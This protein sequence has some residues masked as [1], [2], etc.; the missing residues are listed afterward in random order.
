MLY[1]STSKNTHRG[2]LTYGILF[3]IG[4]PFLLLAIGAALWVGR[5]SSARN[6]LNQ[7]IDRLRGEGLPVDNASTQAY[8]EARTSAEDT[9][10]WLAVLAELTSDPFSQSAAGVPI[11]DGEVEAGV[12]GPGESWAEEQTTR[13]FLNRWQSLHA[14]TMRLATDAGPVRF[15]IDFDSVNTLLPNAQNVRQAARLLSLRGQVAI[16]DR[17]SRMVRRSVESLLGCSNVCSG[18]PFLVSQLITFAIDGM[19]LEVLQQAIRHD[20]LDDDDLKALLPKLL[21]ST[22]I[23]NQWKH[24]M[25]GERAMMLPV[26]DDPS[27]A[28]D[29]GVSTLPGRSRDALVYLNYMSRVSAIPTEDIDEFRSEIA[30]QESELSNLLQGGMLQRYDTI[31]TGLLTPSLAAA[32]DV[33][34]KQATLHRLA[35]LAIA[36]RLYEHEHGGWPQSLEDLAE[37]PLIN[38][39]RLVPPGGKPFGYRVDDSGATIWGFNLRE[40]T[41]T[42]AEPPPTGVDVP[43]SDTNQPWVWELKNDRAPADD[44]PAEQADQQAGA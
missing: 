7:Q 24:A 3:F 18:E 29:H 11:F 22:N 10:A 15:P 37:Y 6:Q 8:Y 42:P 41:S 4:L 25:I 12:P 1:P 27:L 23:G 16:Y 34:A 26:F 5:E 21:A 40:E 13:D 32:G 2:C 31:L 43:S 30:E 14:R 35:A 17:D 28:G 9:A 36:V 33:F 39:E 44:A 19:A 20:V 38:L